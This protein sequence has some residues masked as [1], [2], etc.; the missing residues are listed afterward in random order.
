MSSQTQRDPSSARDTMLALAPEQRAEEVQARLR[1]CVAKA[2]GIPASE[3]DAQRGLTFQGV[4]SVMALGIRNQIEA[5]LGVAVS[6]VSL[7]SGGTLANLSSEILGEL[8]SGSPRS[9]RAED[10]LEAD[11]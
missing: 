1:G 8:S 4:D 3:V 5:E 2:L 9:T 6:V 11:A 7:L 10:E